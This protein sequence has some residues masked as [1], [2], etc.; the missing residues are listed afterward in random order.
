MKLTIRS[1]HMEIT[2]STY[3]EIW[4][5]IYMAFGRVSSLVDEVELTLTDLNGPKGGVDKRCRLNIRGRGIAKVSVEHVG[6]N[7][8]A[9]VAMAAE[10]AEQAILRRL[11]RRRSFAPAMA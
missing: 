8:V 10:R 1:R 5:R 2:T 9:T 11:A 6:V 7:T 3:E 4:R